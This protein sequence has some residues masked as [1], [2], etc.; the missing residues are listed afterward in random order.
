[1]IDA[2]AHVEMFKKEIPAVVEESRKHLIAVVDSITEYRKFHVWKSWELLKPYF[3]FIFPT[4]GFAPNEARRGNWEKV[5]EVEQFILEH[6]DEI[7]AIGEIGLDYYYAKTEEERKNQREIFHYFLNLALELEMPVVLHAR[8]AEREVYE[9]VQRKGLLGY[10]HSYTG[11]IETAKEIA[12][13]G[14]FIGISTGVTFIPEVREV[15]KALDI[16]SILVETDA[17][18]MSPFK[19]E[20]N[21]P[22]YVKVAVEEI[23]KLKELSIEE[24]EKIT[25]ENAVKFF[26][27]NLR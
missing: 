25:H 6:R 23:A 20:K 27:L 24:V 14:H 17:P 9:E 1:M 13:N 4:L 12:E 10:F 11:N 19:G 2:H 8:D 15:V 26:K 22:H 21:K 3:G 5:R 16:E 7:V 18:Y